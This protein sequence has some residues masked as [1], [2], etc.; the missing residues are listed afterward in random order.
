MLLHLLAHTAAAVGLFGLQSCRAAIRFQYFK[1]SLRFPDLS[2]KRFLS[3]KNGGKKQTRLYNSPIG[4]YF[5]MTSVRDGEDR[6]V[7]SVTQASC[8]ELTGK[9]C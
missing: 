4:R 8:S 7:G 1:T 5:C 6:F 2:P 9:T 3:G